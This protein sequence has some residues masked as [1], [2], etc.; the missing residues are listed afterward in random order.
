MAVTDD[1]GD[2][3]AVADPI[4]MHD[5]SMTAGFVVSGSR[6]RPLDGDSKLL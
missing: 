5:G 3:T 1:R 2:G 6:I 4:M